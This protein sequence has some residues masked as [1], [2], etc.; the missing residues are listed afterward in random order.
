MRHDTAETA[1]RRAGET[2]A[3]GFSFEILM[4]TDLFYSVIVNAEVW[5]LFPN[6]L[7]TRALA[8]SG[9]LLGCL[10]HILI[11]AG[12]RLFEG[13]MARLRGKSRSGCPEG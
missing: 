6:W 8:L 13:G 2:A 1:L 10:F 12:R 4:I 3:W 7:S 9:L 5:N 11:E